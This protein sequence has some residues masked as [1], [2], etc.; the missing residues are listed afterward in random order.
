MPAPNR[1]GG[2]TLMEV[3]IAIAVMA[4]LAG[5]AIPLVLK[6]VNQAKEQRARSEMRLVWE[7]LFGA[8]DRIVPNMRA[9]FGFNPNL[10]AGTNSSLPKLTNRLAAPGGNPPIYGL[11]G[12]TFNWGWNGPYWNGSTR[13]IGGFNVPV[14]PWNNPYLLRFV[15]GQGYQVICTGPNGIN[16]TPGNVLQPRNDDT[17]YPVSALNLAAATQ[18]S[19]LQVTIL[20]Q[21]AA[22][23]NVTITIRNRA[24]TGFNVVA[25]T[26]LVVPAGLPLSQTYPGLTPGGMSV[27]VN[28]TTAPAVIFTEP[29]NLVAGEFRVVRYTIN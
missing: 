7:S 18:A 15:T 26:N 25:T 11:N 12:A 17:V 9:D 14:D 5:T 1:R 24:T 22:S 13:A 21:R 20:N 4:I 6:G 23:I 10:V 19:Q 2:F 28:V 3:A 29:S 16:N 27:T 8:Q